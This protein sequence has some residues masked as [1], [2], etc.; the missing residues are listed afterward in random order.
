MQFW[1]WLHPGQ[2]F[3][4]HSAKRQLIFPLLDTEQGQLTLIY[5]YVHQQLHSCVGVL[6][7]VHICI[8]LYTPI[9]YSKFSWSRFLLTRCQRPIIKVAVCTWRPKQQVHSLLMRPWLLLPPPLLLLFWLRCG[10]ILTRILNIARR[11]HTLMLGVSLYRGAVY[12]RRSKSDI[13]YDYVCA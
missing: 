8:P 13:N 5:M 6:T 2:Q 9:Y 1:E 11:G 4:S 12:W 3:E 10:P 7:Y